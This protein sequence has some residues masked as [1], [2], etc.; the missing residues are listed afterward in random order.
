MAVGKAQIAFYCTLFQSLDLLAVMFPVLFSLV[1]KHILADRHFKLATHFFYITD[2]IVWTINL[3]IVKLSNV[4]FC[5]TNEKLKT[6]KI[7]LF[8]YHHG[9]ETKSSV[10]TWK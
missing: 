6:S 9:C 5:W 4:L 8:F 7:Y 1:V 2:L 3:D 10:I